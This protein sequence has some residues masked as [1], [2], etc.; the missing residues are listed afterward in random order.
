MQQE[1]KPQVDIDTKQGPSTV[2]IWEHKH[3]LFAEVKKQQ[4]L[5][6]GG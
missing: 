5:M 6:R 1:W 4:E 3:Q 2:Q